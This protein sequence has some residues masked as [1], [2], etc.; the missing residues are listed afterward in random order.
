MPFYEFRCHQCGLRFEKLC[1]M[2]ESG[3]NIQCPACSAGAPARVMSGF[4]SIG[5]GDKV[6]G[7]G[8]SCS[9]CSSANCSSCSR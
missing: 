8:G 9:G 6:T 1:S 4:N 7:G 2:D 3:A 5:T